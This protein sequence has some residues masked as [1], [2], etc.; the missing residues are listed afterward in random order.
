MARMEQYANNSECI[1]LDIDE[2][3][4][5]SSCLEYADVDVKM[6]FR[7]ASREGRNIFKIFKVKEEGEHPV[8][9]KWRW[10]DW[11]RQQEDKRK[12][13]FAFEEAAKG[14]LKYLD[15]SEELKVS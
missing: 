8:A 12:R 13:C 2:V 11:Q 6:I 7:K 10:D 5:C 14:M 15:D 1:Q 3:E 4:E 9:S